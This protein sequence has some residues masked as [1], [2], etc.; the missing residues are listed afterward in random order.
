MAVLSPIQPIFAVP[1]AIAPTFHASDSCDVVK[2]YIRLVCQGFILIDTA[3]HPSW[4]SIFFTKTS[5]NWLSVVG[6]IPK[7]A[8][9]QLICLGR[10]MK[11]GILLALKCGFIE[12]ASTTSALAR[13]WNDV[14]DLTFAPRKR[15]NALPWQVGAWA[16]YRVP[17]PLACELDL[18]GILHISSYV[19]A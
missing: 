12:F 5:L 11:R 13:H 8:L 7:T 6:G 1:L 19:I 9:S 3:R 4:W 14:W 16:I 18:R 17:I 15:R 2:H 10:I